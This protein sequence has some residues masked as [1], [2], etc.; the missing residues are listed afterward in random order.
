M[1]DSF[2]NGSVVKGLKG[3]KKPPVFGGGFRGSGAVCD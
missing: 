1:L 2:K 3:K